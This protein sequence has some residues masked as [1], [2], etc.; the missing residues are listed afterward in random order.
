MIQPPP[1]R[2]FTYAPPLGLPRILHHDA[3]IL[4]IDKP[5]GL[6]SV[7]GKHHPDSALARIQAE[8]PDAHLVHRLDMATSGV[9]VFPLTP[10]AR[11][12]IARQ[13]Q[14]RQLTKT[15]HARVWGELTGSGTVDL[16][17]RCDW[18]NRPRQMVDFEQGRTATTH[19]ES[20]EVENGTTRV[21]LTPVTGRSH[22][23]RVH[24]LSLGHPIL[25]DRIYAHEAAFRAAERLQLHA[26]ELTLRHPDGGVHVTLRAPIPF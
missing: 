24:M 14:Y 17:L 8:F 6:L 21:A 16:P 23:L 7:P 11:R 18:P 10:E 1:P 4:A 25:G 15:Y 2:P 26:S 12:H 3:H 9:M 22:Q 19:W 5:S 13:F 20:L